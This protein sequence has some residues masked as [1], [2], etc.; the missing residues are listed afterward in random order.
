MGKRR[1][2]I[3]GQRHSDG[4]LGIGHEP[5]GLET[6]DYARQHTRGST[7]LGQTAGPRWHRLEGRPNPHKQHP[8]TQRQERPATGSTPGQQAAQS[9]LIKQSTRAGNFAVLGARATCSKAVYHS[10]THHAGHTPGPSLWPAQARGARS[11]QSKRVPGPGISRPTTQNATHN[12]RDGL[13]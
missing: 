10:P 5:G 2:S 13:A 7:H 1:G 8:H 12:P 4:L 3:T 9:S 6:R 11:D